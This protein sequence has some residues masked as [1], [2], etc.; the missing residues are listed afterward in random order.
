M[1]LLRRKSVLAA[2]IESTSG[3][4]ESLAAA[5]AAF[6]VFD[7]TMTPTIAMTPRP[8]QGSFSSLPAVPE[9]YGGTCTFRTEI[10]GSGAGGV[11][12]WASTFL[13]ACGWTAAGG[14]FTPKSE[15]PGSAVKTLTLGAY[16]DG[17]RILM[18]G[19]SGTFTMTFETGKIASINWTFTGV[20]AGSSAQ[21]L[22]APT[23]PTALPLR[24]GNATFT[25]GS[26]YSP[27]FQSL[28]LDAG[29][30]VVLRECATNTD[31]S[32]Y[33]SAVITNRL[34][35]GTVNPESELDGTKDNYDLWTSMTEE[36]VAFS[37]QN[38]TDKFA[39]AAPKAQ[40]TNVQMG[41]RNGLVTDEITF[42]CNKS[43]AAG[44]D[45]LSFTFS[46]P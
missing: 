45:E 12:G 43:A 18:R 11:P 10:Y 32:G 13:P 37:I 35:T 4:A 42:Q 3:T 15:L 25:F 28:T 1:P 7:L 23:Y 24:V 30:T 17:N 39:V 22:L 26:G 33:A 29:N 31:S 36:A 5:D 9:L 34:P 2:K 6:N 38:A 41:D 46:A 27:C 19:C 16:I 40:R 44:N 8:S 21:T 20:W 14:V